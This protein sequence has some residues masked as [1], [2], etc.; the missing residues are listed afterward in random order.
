MARPARL[1][2]LHVDD[3]VA[4]A[5]TDWLHWMAAERR[6][7][8]HTVNAYRRDIE[9]FF[10]FLSDHLGGFATIS[11]LANLQTRDFR[12]WLAHRAAS[13]LKRTSTA[14]ALS[15]VRNFFNYLNKTGLAHNPAAKAMRAPKLP[16]AVPKPLAVDEAQETLP[17]ARDVASEDWIGKRDIAVLTLLYGAGLR[18]GEAL[19]LDRADAPTDDMMR[20]VGKGQKERIVPVLPIVRQAIADYLAACPYTLPA[21]GPLFV[22]ARGGRLNA[23]NIQ[24][25]MQK[26]RPLL[27]LPDSATPHALRHSFATH[28]LAN[29]GDLRTIQELLGHSSLSTTQRYTDVDETRL[30]A[31]YDQAHPRAK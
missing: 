30:M 7:S 9:G 11:A 20:I 3:R 26:L 4:K 29:G 24:L 19:G 25:L 22:G 1:S 5:A 17:T 15:S 12:A 31:V 8:D 16:H 13:D 14:R 10:R 6:L 27:G 18:I 28:L 21:D 23:R 2:F